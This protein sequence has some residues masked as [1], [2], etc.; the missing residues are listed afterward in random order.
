MYE[1]LGGWSVHL[2]S[3]HSFIP[4]FLAKVQPETSPF[5]PS[6]M[7]SYL[8]FLL[9][10]LGTV[11]HGQLTDYSVSEVDLVIPQPDTT[12]EL[13]P[14]H[15]FPLVL[16]IQN[17][18]LWQKNALNYKLNN[19]TSTDGPVEYLYH[20]SLELRGYDNDW[21]YLSDDVILAPSGR[22]RLEWSFDGTLCDNTTSLDY[23]FYFKT[24]PGAAQKANFSSAASTDCSK[25]TSVLYK[26]GTGPDSSC[27]HSVDRDTDSTPDPCDLIMGPKT[28]ANITQTLDAQFKSHC[29]VD[30]PQ[31]LC[32][33]YKSA[34][35]RLGTGMWLLSLPIMALFW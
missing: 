17:A 35:T 23:G 1:Q 22:Y 32:T 4:A 31:H 10:Q 29:G 11:V 15:R 18:T 26:I 5:I 16:G 21:A 19:A 6:T 13:G 27:G 12:Y 33:N 34:A 3:S 30:H 8:P 2:F 7:H 24:S 20:G 14:D 28:I 25:R 9:S